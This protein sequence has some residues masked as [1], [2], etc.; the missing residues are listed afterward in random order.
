[1]ARRQTGRPRAIPATALTLQAER[2]DGP[3]EE[4]GVPQ[5][6]GG[7]DHVEPLARLRCRL[8]RAG[9]AGFCSHL[10]V[11]MVRSIRPISRMAL[12]NNESVDNSLHSWNIYSA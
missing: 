1:V 3:F 6:D 4:H 7:R 2:G 10:S 9:G 12:K 8:K 5:Y 11:E